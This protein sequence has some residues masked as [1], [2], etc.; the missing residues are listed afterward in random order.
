MPTIKWIGSPNF[1]TGRGGHNVFAIVNHVMC[2]SEGGTDSWF[3]NPNSQVSAHYGVAKD[4]TIHQY[5]KDEDTAWAVGHVNN[6]TWALMGQSAGHP[7]M[8]TISIEHEGYPQDALTE[9]QYQSTL[10]LHK[11][12]MG[13]FPGIK[14][15]ANHIIGHDKL[16][17]V[18]RADCPGPN[19]P[20]S[21]LF[22][23]LGAGSKI[24]APKG[25][26]DDVQVPTLQQGVNGHANAV[27]AV[28]AIVGATADGAFG[29]NT[30]S[31]VQQWQKVHGLNG[32]GVVGPQTWAVML[33]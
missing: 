9:A 15:D 23:D 2:G 22:N 19:F 10:W 5:V 21:R 13:K 6:P 30:T 28:Q 31:K 12:L 20:W 8:V 11:Y 24:T 14:A 7:N 18:N 27:K 29:P 26:E 3:Q 25:V 16:D 1:Y 33:A 4:G 17:S 32:D